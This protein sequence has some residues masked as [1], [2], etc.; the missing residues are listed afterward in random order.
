MVQRFGK[1]TYRLLIFIMF[2]GFASA[3][4]LSFYV[5]W[6]VKYGDYS[7]LKKSTILTRFQEETTL[8]YD[9]ETTRIGSIFESRHR[10]YVPIDEVPAHMINAIVAVEDKNF[11]HHIGV[12]PLAI[13][14]AFFEGLVK[15]GEFR[16]G[17]STLTQQ[18]VK[19]IVDDWEASFARKFR[20]MIRA[21]QL[22]RIYEKRQILEFYLNQFHVV[23][24][25][26]GV[27]IAARYYFN[28]DVRDLTLV[29]SAFIAGSVKGP[30]KYNPF[31][32]FTKKERERAKF[33]ATERKNYVLSQMLE[34][35]WIE[36]E[37]YDEA[38]STDVPFKNGEF[39]TAEVALVNLVQSQLKKKEVLQALGLRDVN[40]LSVAGL[41]VYTTIDA[42]FQKAAQLAMRRNLSR[43]ES[44]LSG[45]AAEPEE[46]YKPL[47]DLKQNEFEYGKVIAAEKK[48]K[49][50]Y[51]IKL[52]F[53][54]PAGV[55]PHSSLVRYAKLLDLV[56]G[57]G[58]NVHLQELAGRIRPGDVLF[59]QVMEYNKETNEAVLEL[60]KRPDISGGLIALDKGE[61]KAIVS[62]FDTLGYNRAMHARRQPG[63]VFKPL[64]YFAAL[65]LGWSLLDRLDNIRKMFPYQGRFY[66]PRPD[67]VPA[68]DSVSMMWAG[69]MSENLASVTLGAQLLDKL[70]LQQ[71]KQLMDSMGLMPM[72]GEAPND[73]HY[74]VAK[75]IGVTLDNEGVHAFQL[76][77]AIDDL[78]PDLVFAGDKT[79]LMRLKQMWW[80]N[81]YIDELRHLLSK[82]GENLSLRELHLRQDLLLNNYKRLVALDSLLVN[83]W[84]ILQ[85][86]VET[87]GL[88][89]LFNEPSLKPILD[90]FRMMSDA[91]YSNLGYFRHLDEE[92][93]SLRPESFPLPEPGGR[94]LTVHD[95]E[96]LVASTGEG[97][98]PQF[99]QILEDIHIDGFLPRKLLERI[100]HIIEERYKDITTGD[101]DDP[102]RLASYF[103]HYDF[104]IG[105]GLKYI[106]QLGHTAG[107]F[108]HL[109]PVLS[110]PLGTN[111]VTVGEVAKIFQTF[112]GGKTYRFFEEGPTNQISFIK[113]IEDRFGTV[114]YKPV[115]QEHAIVPPVIAHH[116]REILR[117]TVTHGTGRRA[118]GELY[119]S[120]NGGSDEQE[121]ADR[122][123]KIRIPAFGK[124]GTTNDFMTAY[125]AGFLPFPT[126]RKKALDP[127]DS[128][129]VATYVGYDL[130]REMRRGRQRIYGGVGALPV[131]TEFLKDVIKIRHYD[132]YLDALDLTVLSKHEWPLTYDATSAPY[133][134]DLSRGV[135]LRSGEDE[136]M[137]MWKLTDLSVTGED[138]QN[139][140]AID[141]NKS[142]IVYLKTDPSVSSLQPYRFFYPFQRPTSTLWE[143]EEID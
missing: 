55:I 60:Q 78:G 82:I 114:L 49:D 135:I 112:I 31:I 54:I 137:E 101:G 15:G 29:E 119:I 143:G 120:A 12:D 3:A 44:I 90:R 81:G 51:E 122:T 53:G 8:F 68:F 27:D 41:K 9:D 80:G 34:Q 133:L 35:G 84:K 11:Y 1:T 121:G 89:K 61:V 124:T 2:A 65:Q 64:V 93:V 14:K 76:K 87:E 24:N 63:S 75:E 28:K 50:Q 86:Y 5:F 108:S 128:Y 66:Y 103:Q 32:K 99:G 141:T 129:V 117:K 39:R 43:L 25:G 106:V 73:Y 7:S 22:E 4:G 94:P 46:H 140:Y 6:Q 70:N 118:R 97:G 95:W 67:H 123:K 132:D 18:T 111:D 42:E 83:D 116:M 134:V 125:F 13:A 104:R 127:D 109:E 16:R 21:L 58:M 57:R 130:N 91:S 36:Q 56:D 26:N 131:W 113:R 40:D 126:E 110:F 77:N 107:V 96:K 115:R 20:E 74:R 100:T 79:V 85:N 38:L 136:D 102:Y 48:G 59:V 62:G 142:S 105:L 92:L 72:S 71:F 33:Y 17:G 47:R 10:R 52:S 98:L 37:D 88:A 19:N 138:F 139:P 23:G 69:I 45:Y 30:S